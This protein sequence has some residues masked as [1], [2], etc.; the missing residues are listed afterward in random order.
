[1]NSSRPSSVQ[2]ICAPVVTV[3]ASSVTRMGRLPGSSMKMALSRPSEISL[4]GEPTTASM[5][6]SGDQVAL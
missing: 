4:S 3:S 2:R 5:S 6:P 1:M